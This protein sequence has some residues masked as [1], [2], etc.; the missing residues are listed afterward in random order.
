[1]KKRGLAGVLACAMLFGALACAEETDDVAERIEHLMSHGK[2]AE[3]TCTGRLIKLRVAPA[4]NK[5]NGRT[6]EGE[7]FIILDTFGE[8][9]YVE[10][11]QKKADNED[12]RRGMT[13]WIHVDNIACEC[14]LI[15]EALAELEAAES[16][17]A[18]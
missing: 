5:M 8:W 13:G 18:Q 7:K 16:E 9:V 11:T 14:D 10:I 12:A 6:V 3:F 17:A 4:A 15:A 1:M 2:R